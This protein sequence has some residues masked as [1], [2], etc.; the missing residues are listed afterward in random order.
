MAV[1]K[2]LN[3]FENVINKQAEVVGKDKAI[4]LAKKAGLSISPEGKIVSCVGNPQLVLLRLIR[5]FTK[6]QNFA[7]LTHCM[8]LINELE[9]LQEELEEV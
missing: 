6:D 2:Y 1:E 3:L 9:R 5:H 8:P 4:S 7:A